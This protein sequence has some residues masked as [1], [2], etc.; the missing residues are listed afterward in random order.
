[1]GRR[2]IHDFCWMWVTWVMGGLVGWLVGVLVGD[3]GTPVKWK[4]FLMFLIFL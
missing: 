1:M 4:W 3:E 2:R